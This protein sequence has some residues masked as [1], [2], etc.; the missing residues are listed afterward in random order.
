MK[1]HL[2]YW[3]LA[4]LLTITVT[5]MQAQ[6]IAEELTADVN[7]AAGIRYVH[8][9][10]TVWPDTPA[11]AGKQPF[12]I[13]HYGCPS[14]YY[15]ERRDS[16]DTPYLTLAKA[17]SLGK[18]TPWGQDVLR[19]VAMVREDAQGRTAELTSQGRTQSRALMRQR[20]E[21]FPDVFTSEGYYSTHSIVLNHCIQTMNESMVQLSQLHQPLQMN[22]KASHKDKPFMNPVDRSLEAERMDSQTKARYDAFVDS[23]TDNTR[24]MASLFNDADYVSAH[25]DATALS[26]QLFVL[27]GSVQASPLHEELT[28]Y[29]IFLPEEIHRHWRCQNAYNYI[30]YGF[31]KLNGSHQPYLQRATLRNMMHMGD[32][33]L[34]RQHP[35]LHMR[36]TH[37]GV[38]MAL[39][40]LMELDGYNVATSNLDSLEHYGWAD[41]RIAPLGGSIEMIHYRR[42]RQDTDV[43][44]KVLLNG[45]EA[46]LPI[47]SD[48]AP[49]YHWNDVKRYYLRKLYR[50]E[51]SRRVKK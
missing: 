19:R 42:D 45:H 46:R 10:T 5:D 40:N 48:C 31:C 12:Y 16:Y 37:E 24:L 34:K 13:N 41:Y 50:Y 33:V 8:P 17:D 44:V 47:A 7:R 30:R 1:K 3:L 27:A 14:A 28:L 35:I 43:L 26:R 6:T 21:R 29:D 49:Y 4:V 18:L 23:N 36:Y 39:A 11:P 9:T 2:P 38:V 22:L 25:I 20:V 15:L 51:N 32:S